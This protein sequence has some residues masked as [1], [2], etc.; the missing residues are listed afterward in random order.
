LLLAIAV[1][2]CGSTMP[3]QAPGTERS[4]GPSQARLEY[5]I[6]PTDGQQPVASDLDVLKQIVEQRLMALDIADATVM[7]EDVRLTIDGLGPDDISRVRSLVAAPGRLDIVPMG[8]DD[9]AEGASIDRSVHPPLFSGD[10]IESASVG[11][12]QNGQPTIDLVLREDGR[13]KFA[14]YTAAS[15]GDRFAITL[16]DRVLSAPIINGAIPDGNVQIT[17]S[18]L[19]G[20]ALADA[21]RIVAILRFGSLPFPIQEV[22]PTPTS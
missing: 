12:D 17:G 22:A 9:V 3:S 4:A 14:A 21:R 13:A 1:T 8:S 7:I 2:A 16:D 5:V 6:V 11:T 15:I 18:G 19:T 20:F 10:Q